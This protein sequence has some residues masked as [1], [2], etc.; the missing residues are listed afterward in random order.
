M[1]VQTMPR[2]DEDAPLSTGPIQTL[3]TQLEQRAEEF[4]MVLPAHIKPDRFQR[5][6]LTAVQQNPELLQC[7]RRSLLTACMKAAQDGLLPDGREAA[8][9]KFNTKMKVAGKWEWVKLAQYMPMVFGLRKKILQSG[10]IEDIFTAVVYKQEVESGK[11]IYEE[12][13]E[14]QLRHKP[15]LDAD[16]RPKDEDIVLAYSVATFGNGLKSFQVM[17]RFEID[18]V[19]EKSQTGAQ[20]DHEGNPRDAK[21][22][23]VEWF[24]EMAKKSVLRRHSKTLPQSGDI[25]ADIEAED[26][27]F[28]ARSTVALL[29]SQRPDDP[30]PVLD[31]RAGGLDE[32]QLAYVDEKPTNIDPETGE[33][34]PKPEPE[35]KPKPRRGR[36]PRAAR[37]EPEPEPEPDLVDDP[38]PEPEDEGDG[39]GAEE[40]EQEDAAAE[41]GDYGTD[42]MGVSQ[43]KYEEAAAIMIERAKKCELMIDLRMLEAE[44]D[45]V[46]MGM[47]LEM[48]KVVDAEFARARERMNTRRTTPGGQ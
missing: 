24:G 46:L 18:D 34:D 39:F 16:F 44:S 26:M 27:A 37:P 1:N 10:E 21:G 43:S 38:E 32:S 5:T 48:A 17:R 13:T 33:I 15:I 28:A 9:V 3:R 14:R 4:R 7:D 35:P 8:I 19:R 47:P 29:D 41:D 40:R 20:F 36:K 11:F 42:E 25:M 30:T 12:G 31:E 22:P 2:A 45:P 23:W 6:V